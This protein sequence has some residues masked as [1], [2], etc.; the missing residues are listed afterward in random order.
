MVGVEVLGISFEWRWEPAKCGLQPFL[1]SFSKQ[2]QQ[3]YPYQKML[4]G[5]GF[6]LSFLPPTNEANGCWVV[7]RSMCTMHLLKDCVSMFPL[8]IGV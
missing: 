3:G 5:W 7:V 6:V 4:H 1:E 8:V 2:P